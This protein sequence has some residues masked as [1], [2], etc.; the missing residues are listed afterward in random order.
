VLDVCRKAI[1]KNKCIRLLI[2][3]LHYALDDIRTGRFRGIIFVGLANLLPDFLALG[4]LRPYL[5]SLAGAQISDCSSVFIRSNVFV[6]TQL[7]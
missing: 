4:F 5:W 7:D 2:H 3:L 1:G 6:N